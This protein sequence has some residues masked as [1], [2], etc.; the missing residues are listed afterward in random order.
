MWLHNLNINITSLLCLNLIWLDVIRCLKT[1]VGV[2]LCLTN[3]P[4]L[5]IL[6][7]LE[8]LGCRLRSVL[9]SRSI[10]ER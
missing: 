3:V 5:M 6:V 7:H 10:F 2:T 9:L 8:I 1:I 4:V